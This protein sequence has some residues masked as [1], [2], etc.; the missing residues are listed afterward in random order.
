MVKNVKIERRNGKPPEITWIIIKNP[1]NYT[2][3]SLK[4]VNSDHRFDIL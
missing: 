2:R 1:E 3:T 4:H